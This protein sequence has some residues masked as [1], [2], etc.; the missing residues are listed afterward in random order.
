MKKLMIAMMLI[1]TFSVAFAQVNISAGNTITEDF[2]I[3]VS[4]TATLP[5]GWKVD[6]L[7]AVR[8]LGT[9]SAASTATDLSAGNN[10]ATNAANGIYNY[11]AGAAAAATD[12]AV[13]FISSGSATKSG[14]L[15]VQLYNNGSSNITSFTI[16]Y[17]VEKYRMGTNAAGFSFQMYYSTD[18]IN[19]T[20]AGTDFLTSFAGGDTSNNGYT[21]AP[22]TIQS[23]NSKTLLQG[24][25]VNSSLYLAWNY[26]VTSGTTTSNAQAL[27]ID[28]V[29]IEAIGA[30][31]PTIN[32]SGSLNAFIAYVGNP[33][34]TQSYNL[35]GSNLS[36]NIS[37][38]APA[39]FALSTDNVIFSSSLSLAPSYSGLIYVRLTGASIGYFSGNI[40]HSSASATSVD[41]PVQG[42]VTVP[43]PTF[44]FSPSSLSGFTYIVGEGP[45]EAQSINV[46]GS[47][48]NEN[49]IARASDSYE[50]SFSTD[51][52]YTGMLVINPIDGEIDRNFYVRLKAGLDIGTYDEIVQ[53]QF[54]IA[55]GNNIPV[56][57]DVKPIP[58]AAEVLLRPSQ[59]DISGAT[60]ESAVLMKVENYESDEAKYRLY[61]DGSYYYYCWDSTTAEYISNNAYA[62]GPSVPGTPSSSSTWW[63]VFQRGNNNSTIASY[64][65]R[66]NPYSTPNYQTVA[67]PEATEITNPITISDA[68][69]QFSIWNNYTNKYVILA[70]DAEL[71]GT[72]ISATSSALDSGA[73]S[74]VVEDGSIIKRIEVRDLDNTLIESLT[75]TWPVLYD[76]TDGFPTVTAGT[77]I[78]ITGGNANYSIGVDSNIP[79][80]TF[81]PVFQ[82]HLTLIGAG[83][84]NFTIQTTEDWVAY[85]Q[86]SAWYSYEVKEG[87]VSFQ[88]LASKDSEIE[89]I[90]G[91]GGEPTLP[92]EL[93]HFSAII[94]AQNFVQITWVSQSESNLIGYNLYRNSSLD[95][96]TAVRICELIPGT[97]SSIAQTYIYV[98]KE[99][100][101]SGNYYYWLQNVDMDGNSSY[102]GPV[103]VI[104]SQQDGSSSPSLPFITRLENAYPNPFNP[105]TSI[106]YQ[107]KAPG[108]VKIDIYNLKG[109]KV[110]SFENSHAAAGFYQIN[111]DGRDSFGNS[112]SSGVYQYKMSSEGYSS[113]KKMVLKK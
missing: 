39:G 4:G 19:W 99:L 26:S 48:L 58:P 18:G 95:L 8:T 49:F 82:E 35:S 77:S 37:V 29:S 43:S 45:S 3:G 106:R 93:S 23:V 111:W 68:D 36:G 32:V 113:S 31:E 55:A 97:N 34:L 102:H 76:F 88:V 84:W 2:S 33:S 10:M 78:T 5:S 107:I 12:R 98:D 52:G 25:N 42:N 13:G 41:L 75:G 61:K 109:Q 92:V 79:N 28:D 50:I 90:I 60:S 105:N 100:S 72:L 108:K 104:F 66:L 53:I 51:S 9:Y 1:F 80:P 24:L 44:G 57:G 64:R 70:Y 15:Y 112:V 71:D 86:A 65:D 20:S 30:I 94:N 62:N 89:L 63:I 21:N 91:S 69:M 73:F 38:T 54:T 59:I 40:V 103:S 87:E 22:G 47:N 27:G 17:N 96:S 85:R 6:K 83:P 46:Y 81:V 110:R 16:S 7:T 74:L 101:Q 11:G 67:L 56:K 14:N